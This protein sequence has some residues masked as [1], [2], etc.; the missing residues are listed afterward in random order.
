MK[1]RIL[2]L[3]FL[4]MFPSFAFAVTVDELNVQIA[5][6]QA[7]I[8]EL[9]TKLD[10]LLARDK[11]IV[12]AKNAKIVG[13]QTRI[14]K[15]I[16]LMDATDKK[17]LK[18]DYQA[19]ID[20]WTVFLNKATS[21]IHGRVANRDKK[22]VQYQTEINN[23]TNQ[24]LELYAKIKELTV[25]KYTITVK[26]M[27]LCTGSCPSEYREFTVEIYQGEDFGFNWY[28]YAGY[29]ISDVLVDGVSTGVS[30]SFNS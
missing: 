22:E 29:L 1:N 30:T 24:I 28:N 7:I 23:Y 11:R 12:D 16:N 6:Y 15:W 19:K 17:N 10:K 9:Q 2:C 20:K 13:L 27:G 18:M 4:L 26:G 5:G 14:D 25:P 3:M 21:E 8:D